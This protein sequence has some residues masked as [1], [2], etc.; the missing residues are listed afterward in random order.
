[1]TNSHSHSNNAL[2]TLTA[3]F[4][5]PDGIRYRS[6]F[7]PVGRDA[8]SS[9]IIVGSVSIPITSVHALVFCETMHAFNNIYDAR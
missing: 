8:N 5:A 1:M 7:G 3:P 4:F 6:V 9:V 2:V